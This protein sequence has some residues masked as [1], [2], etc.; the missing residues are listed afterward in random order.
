MLGELFTL[1][2]VFPP[3][4]LMPWGFINCLK[5]F[6]RNLTLLEEN[7]IGLAISRGEK[8]HI[9][10]WIDLAFSKEFGGIGLIETRTLN[11][12][13]LAK[14]IMKIE[15]DD[16]SLC[17]ELLLRKKYLHG[18]GIFQCNSDK[19]SQFWKGLL[20]IR[21]WM[22]L[23]SE[24]LLGDGSHIW[25]WYDIWHGTCPLK[26]I[27][28]KI[29]EICNQ[30]N[31]TV[32]EVP[33]KGADYLTF[34]RSFGEI[35]VQQWQ[36]LWEIIDEIELQN[37]PDILTWSLAANKQFTTKSLYEA[38]SFRGIKDINMQ[39]VWK[40]PTVLPQWKWSTSFGWQWRTEFN[41]QGN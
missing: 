10:R 3:S 39:R 17:I 6:I 34:R 38:I 36:D 41:L 24:W 23:G 4:L 20:N 30:Q 33:T 18:K 21:R 37:S 28:P 25:F 5:G 14:W 12:A 32:S 22:Q 29:F 11:T 31:I 1:M 9:V 2:L 16:K 40:C 7:I 19:G 15:S 8:Y 27:F 35:E 26:T 13:L